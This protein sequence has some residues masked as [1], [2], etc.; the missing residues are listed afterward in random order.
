MRI[1]SEKHGR[2]PCGLPVSVSQVVEAGPAL[3]GRFGLRHRPTGLLKER[4][5]Y[6]RF[7]DAMEDAVEGQRALGA[8]YE[9]I[10]FA[11][12]LTARSL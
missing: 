1:R 3:V 7:Y 4:G 8:E 12:T 11:D 2:R 6:A 9:V 5:Q 10:F